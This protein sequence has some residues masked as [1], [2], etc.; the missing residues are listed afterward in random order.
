M[1][2]G[3]RDG[4]LGKGGKEATHRSKSNSRGSQTYQA[5]VSGMRL[6]DSIC[7][8]IA[9]LV[10]DGLDLS[11]VLRDDQ[12]ADNAFEPVERR[13]GVSDECPTT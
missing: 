1:S 11:I 12:L 5:T 9:E 2:N 6:M 13:R 4:G 3:Q 7:I 10:D 8:V